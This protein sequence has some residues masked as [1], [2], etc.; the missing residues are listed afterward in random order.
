MCVGKLNKGD[1]HETWCFC[2]QVY[3]DQMMSNSQLNNEIFA[4]ISIRGVL[5]G[6]AAGCLQLS[7]RICLKGA[8]VIT[9]DGE[10]KPAVELLIWFWSEGPGGK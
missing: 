10:A 9:V 7:T 5:K 4:V 3:L 8:F 2:L 6:Q 1:Q